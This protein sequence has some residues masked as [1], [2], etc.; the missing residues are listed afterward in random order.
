ML[1]YEKV[2]MAYN[3]GLNIFQGLQIYMKNQ[4][5]QVSWLHDSRRDGRLQGDDSIAASM[6]LI[7]SLMY[8]SCLL[9]VMHFV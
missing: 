3:Y 6:N 7:L 4:L 9:V 1:Q 8:P 5:G 2:Q